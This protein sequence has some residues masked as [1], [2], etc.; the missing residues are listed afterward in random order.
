MNWGQDGRVCEVSEDR[1]RRRRR[2]TSEYP[3]ADGEIAEVLEVYREGGTIELVFATEAGFERLAAALSMG[4]SASMDQAEFVSQL[5][6]RKTQAFAGGATIVDDLGHTLATY[7]GTVPAVLEFDAA[8]TVRS[9][10]V[11]TAQGEVVVPVPPERDL[12]RGKDLRHR[13]T[14]PMHI[15]HKGISR[16]GST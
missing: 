1:D 3:V 2:L 13:D 7:E 8:P 5:L 4:A 16:Q 15:P 12:R 10:T 6:S 14:G 9:V 11:R